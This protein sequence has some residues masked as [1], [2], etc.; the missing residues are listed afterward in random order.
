MPIFSKQWIACRLSCAAMCGVGCTKPS[1]CIEYTC[2]YGP[3][4]PTPMGGSRKSSN[5]KQAK[6]IVKEAVMGGGEA[7]LSLA[8]GIIV[9]WLCP[10]PIVVYIVY[11]VL[12]GHVQYQ[13]WHWLQQVLTTWPRLIACGALGLGLIA[14][15]WQL[16]PPARDWTVLHPLTFTYYT[17]IFTGTLLLAGAWRCLWKINN[18]K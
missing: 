16:P 9:L 18:V 14:G 7:A 17:L 3:S 13:A 10:L 6:D 4:M 11:I 1:I 2:W 15:S 5:M 12:L 8:L